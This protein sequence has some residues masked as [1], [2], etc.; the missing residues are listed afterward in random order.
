[1]ETVA[2]ATQNF[3]FKEK[4]RRYSRENKQFENFESKF[5]CKLT[6]WKQHSE[7]VGENQEIIWKIVIISDESFLLHRE[8]QTKQENLFCRVDPKQSWKHNKSSKQWR[9]TWILVRRPVPGTW[10]RQNWRTR[11]SES[12]GRAGRENSRKRH[13]TN[14]AEQFM[15]CTLISQVP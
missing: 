13:L 15:N 8:L 11:G 6:I 2:R 7:L 4:Q 5:H 10:G 9:T 3:K 12:E 14:S 1:M